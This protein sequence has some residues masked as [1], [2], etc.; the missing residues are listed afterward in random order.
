MRILCDFCYER[1]ATV[2]LTNKVAG[3]PDREMHLCS[4]C[5]PLNNSEK[6][7]QETLNKFLAQMSSR[8]PKDH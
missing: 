4:V 1:Q 5:C 8:Q 6:E 3:Q 2:H 7:D